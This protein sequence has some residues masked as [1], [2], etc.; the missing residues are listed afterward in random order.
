MKDNL[1]YYVHHKTIQTSAKGINKMSK[2]RL[3][4]EEKR[5][6]CFSKIKS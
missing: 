6:S 3:H 5:K 2:M 1:K 4:R